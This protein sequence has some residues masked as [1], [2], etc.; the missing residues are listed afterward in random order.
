MFQFAEQDQNPT[1]EQARQIAA[2]Q[3][4][5]IANFY[6][7]G[8]G[9]NCDQRGSYNAQAAALAKTRTLEFLSRHVG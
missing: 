4:G 8:H 2:A 1:L 3:P 9:F 5:A 7:A 6:P